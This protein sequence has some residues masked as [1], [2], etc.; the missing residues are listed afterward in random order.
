M[1][2]LKIV[3]YDAKSDD[4]HFKLLIENKKGLIPQES[5]KH[6]YVPIYVCKVSHTLAST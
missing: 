6:N 3:N 4:N 2:I 1:T 5:D